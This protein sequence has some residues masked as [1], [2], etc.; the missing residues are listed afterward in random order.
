MASPFF[1]NLEVQHRKKI[2]VTDFWKIHFNRLRLSLHTNSSTLSSFIEESGIHR[3]GLALAG[4]MNVYNHRQIQMIGNTEWHFLESVGEEKRKEIFR[5]LIDYPNPLWILTGGLQPHAELLQL[6]EEQ[7]M[8]LMTS[9]LPTVDF[10]RVVQHFFENHFAPYYSV[11][12]SFVDVYGI[13]MLY[14]GSSNV[15]KSECVLD[16]IERGHRLVADDAVNVSRIGNSLIGR[17]NS[18]VKHHMEIRGVGIIDVKTMFGIHAVRKAK[19]IEMLIELQHWNKEKT[20]DRTGLD[21]E[22]QDI[23]GIKIPHIIIPV[24]PGKNLTVISEVIAMNTLMKM[25]GIDTAKDFNNAL[26]KTIQRRKTGEEEIDFSSEED[27]T[28]WDTHE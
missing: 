12:G 2:S 21:A 26:L 5:H 13:G 20:Y 23:L 28:F 22:T 15:G 18:L 25:N 9:L 14:I 7:H 1:Q 24:S 6:C 10:S 11:H 19:K 3:P 8:P 17:A 16:L 4:F 27:S